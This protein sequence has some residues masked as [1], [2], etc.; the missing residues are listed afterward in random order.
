MFDWLEETIVNYIINVY[1]GL[2]TGLGDIY[3]NAVMSPSEFNPTI[4]NAVSEFNQNAVLPVA[5]SI[6][7]LFLLLELHSIFQR[8]DVKGWDS[9]YWVAM[10]MMKCVF[11]KIMMENM[12]VIINAI[13]EL[14]STIISG[15]T[16]SVVAVTPNVTELADSI[17]NQSTLTLLGYF[18]TSLII[19]LFGGA[20]RILAD[21]VVKLRF[22]EIYVFTGIA[23]IPFATF[24]SKEYSVIGKNFI[25]RMCALALHVVFI[26]LVL[27]MYSVLVSAS[28]PTLSASEPMNALFEALGYSVLAVISLFQTGSWAKSLMGV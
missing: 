23:A 8:A 15:N 18:I 10:I 26:V 6:L 9:I 24:C 11:A 3:T 7:S 5:W 21:I 19:S 20:A 2:Y 28:Q 17:T 12:T 16:Q 4:W 13:F 1:M 25:K 14:S 27:Y 22:I